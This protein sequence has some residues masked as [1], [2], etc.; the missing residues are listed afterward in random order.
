[1][2]LTHCSLFTS[3][4]MIQRSVMTV[5]LSSFAYLVFRR[6]FQPNDP[7]R[8]HAYGHLLSSYIRPELRVQTDKGQCMH[9]DFIGVAT[10]YTNYCYDTIYLC[11]E[12]RQVNPRLTV[13]FGSN[14]NSPQSAP[15]DCV[16]K[17]YP[18]SCLDS[19]FRENSLFYEA[20]LEK[21]APDNTLEAARAQRGR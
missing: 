21:P 7:S 3:C 14:F 15:A 12:S 4:I 17:Q 20:M 11:T 9:T 10:L 2:V 5:S 8:F 13:N 16:G 18:V 19:I 1:M 6:A